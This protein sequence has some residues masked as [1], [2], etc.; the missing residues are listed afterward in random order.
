MLVP[1]AAGTLMGFFGAIPVA[2]PV[3]AIVL[4]FG[5][6]QQ[7]RRGQAVALGA[8]LAESIYVLLAFFGFNL[9][10][11]SVPHLLVA[12]KYLASAILGAL[13]LYFLFSKSSRELGADAVPVKSGGKRSAFGVGFGVSIVN[14]TLLATWTT[15]ITSLYSY[16]IFPYSTANA[17]LFSVGVTL[18]IAGW[19]WLFLFLIHKNHDRLNPIWIR[20]TLA[21][22]GIF[23]IALSVW[24]LF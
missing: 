20:R 19:F 21:V 7:A 13:G 14:P 9:F 11:N 15:V 22:I 1:L 4:R 2:G 5:L 10:L 24:N 17:V 18:G 12:S 23:L 3:S 16:Q 6:K 8:A